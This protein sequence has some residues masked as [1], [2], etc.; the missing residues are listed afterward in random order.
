MKTVKEQR[1]EL[2]QMLQSY[3]GKKSSVEKKYK[4]TDETTVVHGDITLYRIQALRDF[5]DVKKGDLLPALVQGEGAALSITKQIYAANRAKLCDVLI[6]G[7][8]GGSLEDLLPFSEE[9]V[10][11]AIASSEIPV[12]SAVGH[13]IDWALSD[14]AADKRAP[15]PSAAAE[16]VVPE[17]SSVLQYLNTKKQ[18]LYTNISSRVERVKLLVKSFDPQNLELKVRSIEQPLLARFDNCKEALGTNITQRLRDTRQLID[19]CVTVLENASPQTILD[20][21]YSMVR[22]KDTNKII[23]NADDVTSGCKIEIIPAKG[24]ITACV[25]STEQEK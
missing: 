23:R 24:K 17:I 13:E 7:R 20:R 6:V 12:V 2:I 25:E 8:G 3:F 15:T 11:R 21:G 4:L 16:I 14:Y 5:G 1:S 18:E 10:V 9:M 19:T 22:D